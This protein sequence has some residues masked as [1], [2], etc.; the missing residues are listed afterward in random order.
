M[1]I[2]PLISETLIV[3]AQPGCVSLQTRS[4][5]VYSTDTVYHETTKNNFQG[6]HKLLQAHKKYVLKTKN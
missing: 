1:V 4:P 2:S 5:V 6:S 3:S